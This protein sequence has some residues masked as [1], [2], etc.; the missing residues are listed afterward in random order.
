MTPL[1][2]EFTVDAPCAHAFDVW[3][4]RPS[5]WW[6]K[7]HTVAGTD[8]VEIV[9]EGQP[10]GRIF[11]RTGDGAE[12]DWGEVTAWEPPTRLAYRWHL[13]FDKAEATDISVTFTPDGDGTSVRIEQR[14]WERLGAAG[15]QRRTN[16]QGAWLAITPFYVEACR[17]IAQEM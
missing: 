3:A 6:P 17:T 4:N 14:G 5:L 16:T 12:H 13:F 11:E 1:I 9:F 10:G 7:A 8:D 15:P 2:V